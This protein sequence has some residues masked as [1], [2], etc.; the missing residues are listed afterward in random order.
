[1]AEKRCEF[2]DVHGEF[3]ERLTSLEITVQE[4]FKMADTVRNWLM[5]LV[6]IV[7]V[8]TGSLIWFLATDHS[9]QVGIAHWLNAN[10][11][12]VARLIY[13]DEQRHRP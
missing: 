5:G 12:K 6:A 9:E 8:Q 11:E 10:Q 1:M 7:I 4:R 3:T 2:C 13:E